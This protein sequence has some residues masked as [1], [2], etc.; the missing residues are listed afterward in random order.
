MIVGQT[1]NLKTYDL[2]KINNFDLICVMMKWVEDKL[3][4]LKNFGPMVRLKNFYENLILFGNRN[5][6]SASSVKKNFLINNKINFNEK[7]SL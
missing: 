5:S 1:I 7:K 4:I 6:T 2:I 3:I